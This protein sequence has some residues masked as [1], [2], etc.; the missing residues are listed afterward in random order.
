M[1][2]LAA[3]A[4]SGSI[5]SSSYTDI[6]TEYQQLLTEVG[7]IVTATNFNG[8]ALIDGS[9]NQDFLI[10][11]NASTDT[12]TADLSTV[13]ATATGLGINGTDVTSS[14]NAAT[15]SAALDTAI[16][17]ISTYRSTVGAL[18]SRFTFQSDVINTRVDALESAKS[19]ITDTDIAAEQTNYTNEQVKTETA[20]SAL[21][22]ANQMNSALLKLV[23]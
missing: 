17:S 5:G 3:E 18:E 7:T 16:Q 21:A 6:D 19:A 15:A 10:G 2:S 13:D 4:Q 9:Y 20:I 11:T 23:Q 8:V 1:K 12:I 14:A 22:Q